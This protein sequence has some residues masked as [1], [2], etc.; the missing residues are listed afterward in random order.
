MAKPSPL[1]STTTAVMMVCR[2]RPPKLFV[3]NISAYLSID[4][5]AATWNLDQ[6]WKVILSKMS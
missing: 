5:P 3:P 2:A 4:R 6:K 1:L